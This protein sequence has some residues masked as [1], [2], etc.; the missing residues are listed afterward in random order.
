MSFVSL[1]SYMGCK[2]A[3]RRFARIDEMAF[4]TA[5]T[6]ELLGHTLAAQ[7]RAIFFHE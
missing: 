4:C 3:E 5:L 2:V 7:S 1:Q 6:C